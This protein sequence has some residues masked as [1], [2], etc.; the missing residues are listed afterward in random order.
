MKLKKI[1]DKNTKH[2]NKNTSDA[3]LDF[4]VSKDI[5]KIFLL[6]GGAICIYCRC[7]F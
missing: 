7:L 2:P 4:L 5:K 1:K 6:T 3:I